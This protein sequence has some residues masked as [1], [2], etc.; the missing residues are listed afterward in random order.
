MSHVSSAD[1]SEFRQEVRDFLDHA[2]TPEL[3]RAGESEHGVYA[4]PSIGRQWHKALYDKGWIT[5][6]WPSEYGG[7]GWSVQQ[8]YIFER[9][10]ALYGTPNL[11]SAGLGMCGPILITYGNT[12]QKARFLPRLRSGEDYWCQGYSEPS[13]GSDL[14]SLACRA[15]R[16][17]D[18]YVVEGT[19]IWTTHA[20]HADWIFMLVRTSSEG[21]PQHGI[22]FLLADMRSLGITIRPI[23]NMAGEHEYNQLF[24]DQ[25][26]VPV[27]NRVGE[28][29][30]GWT[31]AKRLLEFERGIFFGP[32]VL[33]ILRHAQ[34]MAR[35]TGAWNDKSFRRQFAEISICREALEASELRLINAGAHDSGDYTASLLKL[36]GTEL[37][38]K[39]TE[40]SVL[41]SGH[42]AA[43]TYK[44]AEGDAAVE[45]GAVAMARYLHKRAA[46]IV[47][48]TSE[49]QRNI[50]A[51]TALRL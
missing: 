12:D 33:R 5:P 14:A 16:D 44:S 3:R 17:G 38:Q 51:K 10:C 46:T 40:V 29:G 23:Y 11:S 8:K 28:E 50:L 35:A 2:L 21:R 41:A 34:H 36:A 9:E 20:Q 37:W 18:E 4:D 25:V 31:I 32:R 49:V 45:G 26:R 22:T 7:I 27:A 42:A 24:F 47:A 6:L 15:V 1:L 43:Y 48:G 39:A 30:S 19:K 13:S